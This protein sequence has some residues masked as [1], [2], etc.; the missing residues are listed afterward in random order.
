VFA[1][2][3]DV[4]VLVPHADGLLFIQQKSSLRPNFRSGLNPCAAVFEKIKMLLSSFFVSASFFL[5]LKSFVSMTCPYSGRSFND[6]SFTSPAFCRN[7]FNSF[8]SGSVGFAFR[9]NLPDQMSPSFTSAP[10]G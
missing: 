3:H 7:R 2:E 5:R 1:S 8:S 9:G 4:A 10:T 6:A